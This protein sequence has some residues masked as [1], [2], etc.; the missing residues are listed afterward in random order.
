MWVN[1]HNFKS[2]DLKTQHK[3]ICGEKSSCGE[4]IIVWRQKVLKV[5]VNTHNFKSFDL[6]TQH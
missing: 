1:T 2:F 4:K 6:K 3:G 5:W